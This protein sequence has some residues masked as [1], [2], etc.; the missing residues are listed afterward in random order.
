MPLVL[1]MRFMSM[2]FPEAA[3]QRVLESPVASK[4]IHGFVLPGRS[5]PDV[6]CAGGRYGSFRPRFFP[7]KMHPESSPARI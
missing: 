7:K 5:T 6:V 1:R 2:G 3:T 4:S